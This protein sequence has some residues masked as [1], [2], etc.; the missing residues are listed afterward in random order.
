M[1]SDEGKAKI[2]ADLEAKDLGTASVQYKLRDWLFSRQRYW[3]EPFPVT[4]V[5]QADYE[6]A[7][8]TRTIPFQEFIPEEPV[9]FEVDGELRYALPV[10]TSQLPLELPEVESY[11]PTGTGESPLSSVPE[12]LNVWLNI[13]TGEA[14]S[15]SGGESRR[16]RLGFRYPRNQYH[17]SMGGF[18]LVLPALLRSEKQ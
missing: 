2:I 7:A 8:A 16:R 13:E 15:R 5:S 1:E 14:L 10:P 3:G 11:E 6:R 17:A 18:L 4:W 9:T 12:W